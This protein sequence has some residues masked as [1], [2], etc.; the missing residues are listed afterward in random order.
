[1]PWYRRTGIADPSGGSFDQTSVSSA[2]SVT[3]GAGS[4]VREGGSEDVLSDSPQQA[5]T[6][7]APQT[8]RAA[9]AITAGP[10]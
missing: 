10:V 3:S 7:Q 1:M 9:D 5:S 8:I 6:T 4:G 2:V